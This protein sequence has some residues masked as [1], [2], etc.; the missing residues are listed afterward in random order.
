MII[1]IQWITVSYAIDVSKLVSIYADIYEN[2]I[3]KLNLVYKI[4]N[5]FFDFRPSNIVSELKLDRP[6]YHETTS[7]GHFGKTGL[8][9][10]RV[11]KVKKI[12]EFIKAYNK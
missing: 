10:E 6:I 2:D 5:K 12:Q 7:Y 1:E 4:I 3:N 11:N 9:Y 8:P